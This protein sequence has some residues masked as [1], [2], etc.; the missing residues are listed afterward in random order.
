M[1]S[2]YETLE[3]RRKE[4]YEQRDY[5]VTVWRDMRDYIMPDRG[6]FEGE[7]PNRGERRDQNVI[8]GTPILAARILAAGM[9]SGLTSPARPWFRLTTHDFELAQYGPV[10]IWLEEV[11]RRM[12]AIFAKSNVYNSLHAIYYELGVF[13][14]A[15]LLI[16]SNYDTVIRARALTCGEY[17]LGTN[18]ELKVDSL[19]RTIYLTGLQ[20]INA[21]GKENLA[22]STRS[23]AEN[24][25]EKW[26][27]VYHAIEPNDNR[28]KLNEVSKDF[29]YRSVYW[30]PGQASQNKFLK[31]SG[32]MSNPIMAPRWDVVSSDVYGRGPGWIALGDSKMLQKLV[33]DSLVG[34][35]K[36]VNPPL[37]AP[38]SSK[39]HGLNMLPGGVS[40]YDVSS[41]PAPIVPAYQ[42]SLPI[43]SLEI[44]IQRVQE[45]I[46]AAF[47]VDLFLMLAVQ[48]RPQMTARE[49]A[50][51]H[52]EK[53]LML[54]PVLD[55]L[56][57]ELLD[58]L[59]DRTFD[60]MVE[61]GIIPTPPQELQGQQLKVD[62]ISILAQAQKM[63]AT[64]GMEQLI[65]F[66]GGISP[67]K[68]DVID[69]ID[70]DELV[71][72]YADALGTPPTLVRDD[73]VVAQ[74][75]VARAKQQQV[76]AQAQAAMATVQGAKTLSETKLNDNNA[77][78]A[79]LNRQ[80]PTIV[81]GAGV[82][83]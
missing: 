10:K 59:I 17:A 2:A 21:F 65:S 4:L 57:N 13:G 32:F 16:L 78:T 35:D 44:K 62:Y 31:V 58:P 52:E 47:Y 15:A 34:I 51:R 37:I 82:T 45:A 48:D 55:R 46:K 28:I 76:M 9:L 6:F 7:E 27:K 11:Q 70:F 74:T 54:G 30:E 14:T 66:V 42:V 33:E 77:L 71:D 18:P 25:P 5:W 56:Q 79:L 75:R 83:R 1:F 24:S 29:I 38:T 3:R 22:D 68:P 50:E 69:K 40:F 20:M 64:V 73:E 67:M 36:M 63:V 81:P 23:T 72:Q 26:H 39:T 60:L 8:D 49:V 80:A 19:Y 43:D 12:M 53:L 61:A 41:G